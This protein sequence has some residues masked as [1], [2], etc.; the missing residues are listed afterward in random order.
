VLI[1][2]EIFWIVV[3]LCPCVLRWVGSRGGLNLIGIHRERKRGG[4]EREATNRICANV[5]AAST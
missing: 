1:L 5:Q 2:E 4:R 3:S